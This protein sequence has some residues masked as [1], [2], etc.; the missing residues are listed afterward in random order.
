MN[1]SKRSTKV[2]AYFSGLGKA[3]SIVLYD[4]L[5]DKFTD[6]EIVSILA[7]EAGHDKYRHT[8]VNFVFGLL[9]SAITLAA[10]YFVVTNAAVAA[11]FGF[12]D[13]NVAFGLHIFFIVY[14]PL[15]LIISI[16]K[17]ALSRKFEYQAD[18]YAA[19]TAGAAPMISALKKLAGVTF[20]NLVPHP[21]VVAMTYTHP[22]IAARVDNIAK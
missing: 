14:T 22:P 15:A 11:A 20:A 9:T 21:F 16:P 5:L 18:S 7:H 19:E 8:A 4:T 1:A 6:D 3:K 10:A 13:V 17:N 12:A 2:N